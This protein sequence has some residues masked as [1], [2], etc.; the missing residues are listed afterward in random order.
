VN[1]RLLI[2]ADA[3]VADVD[4]LPRRVRDVID[5]AAE[6]Y[7]VTPTL[8]GRLAWLAW[9]LNP[10]RHAADERLDN[11]LGQVRSLGAHARGTTGDDTILTAFADAIAEF[12]PDQIVVALRSAEHANWQ[13]RG[14][15]KRVREQFGLPLTTF[16]VDPQG[17]VPTPSDVD[18]VTA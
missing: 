18:S 13:E 2:V 8:P 17:H 6:V 11:M 15:I 3:A 5:E 1:Q 9:E 12:G 14:L 16:A 10:A 4:E 7:V